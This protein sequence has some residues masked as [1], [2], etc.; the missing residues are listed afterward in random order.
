MSK[1]PAAA[2]EAA[3]AGKALRLDAAADAGHGAVPPE[4]AAAAASKKGR[5]GKFKKAAFVSA[6]FR[7]PARPSIGG[8]AAVAAVPGVDACAMVLLTRPGSLELGLM[9]IR[10]T[11]HEGP[12]HHTSSVCC[13]LVCVATRQ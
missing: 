11:R 13:V 4:A 3:P 7:V 1:R 5:G 2:P 12:P 10:K 6:L 8:V 9:V